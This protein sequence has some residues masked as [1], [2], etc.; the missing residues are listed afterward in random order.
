MGNLDYAEKESSQIERKVKSKEQLSQEQNSWL[1]NNAQNL[2]SQ[3]LY[4]L[5]NNY[6]LLNPKIQT[7]TQNFK[8]R[9]SKALNAVLTKESTPNEIKENPEITKKLNLYQNLT[10]NLKTSLKDIQNNLNDSTS[11]SL[12]AMDALV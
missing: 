5:I 12:I 10:N 7:E 1:Q 6:S 3:D 4:S 11:L 2:S 8:S 9:N